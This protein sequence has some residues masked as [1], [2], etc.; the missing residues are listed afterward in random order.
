MKKRPRLFDF[1]GE[2]VRLAEHDSDALY[3]SNHTPVFVFIK[4]V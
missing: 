3:N 2:D 4:Y 1:Y